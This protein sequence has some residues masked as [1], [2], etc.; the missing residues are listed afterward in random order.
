MG[1]SKKIIIGTV[2]GITAAA[3]TAGGICLWRYY[4]KGSSVDGLAYVCAVSE[5]NTASVS[6]ANLQF[7]GVVEPQETVDIKVDISKTISEISV[8]EGDHVKAGDPLFTYDVEAMEL[9][10]QQGEVEIER[11]QNEITANEKQIEQLESEKMKANADDQL[12]YTTQ[13]QSLQT[14]IAKTKYDIKTKEIELEKLSKTIKNATVKSEIT[15]TVQS[16]KTVENLQNEGGDVLMK[17]MSDGEFRVKCVASEQNMY[18]IYVD[19]PV[20]VHSRIDDTVWSGTITEI[21]TEAENDQNNMMYYNSD[22]MT[23]ASKYPFYITLDSSEGLML[24]QHILVSPNQESTVEKKGI[25]LYSDYIITDEDG[26]SY[27]WAAGSG[28]KLEKRKV[29]L[30]ECDEMMGDCQIVSGLEDDDL[31]AFPSASYKEGMRVTT[32]EEEA[33]NADNGEMPIDSEMPIDGEIPAD[34]EMPIDDEIPID[35]EM[36]ID[37]DMLIDGDLPVEEGGAFDGT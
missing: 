23:T 3:V 16:L 18:M 32:N 22:E 15:G 11:M 24:G 9:E 8:Q 27:V 1:K 26:E 33:A 21:G 10:L 34:G 29:E 12:S 31:I 28:D 7:S 5:V 36:P 2:A 13:I 19:E 6:A 37:D 30:G 25:W 35:G 14:D 4:G 17:V 20:A